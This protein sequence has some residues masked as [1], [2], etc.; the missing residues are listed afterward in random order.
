M[1]Y[2]RQSSCFCVECCWARVY[3]RPEPHVVIKKPTT[4]R[5]TAKTFGVSKKR[6]RYIKKL[7]DEV[8][9]TN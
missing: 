9:D 5:K 3:E 1:K 7:V 2:D 4:P 8:L 6:L